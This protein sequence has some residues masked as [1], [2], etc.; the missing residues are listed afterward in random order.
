MATILEFRSEPGRASSRATADALHSTGK[1]VIFPG[2]RVS[3]WDDLAIAAD[4][5]PPAAEATCKR[6]TKA[7]RRK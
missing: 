1:I 5:L 7:R 2:I 6:K 4:E 3:Y